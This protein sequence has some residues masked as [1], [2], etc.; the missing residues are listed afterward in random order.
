MFLP[1]YGIH[2]TVKDKKRKYLNWPIKEVMGTMSIFKLM[3]SI[4]KD[5]LFHLWLKTTYSIKE[6]ELFIYLCRGMSTVFLLMLNN[7][8][9][10]IFFTK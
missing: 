2:F 9:M 3:F 10:Y 1:S 8:T 6:I 5:L 7:Y 4:T